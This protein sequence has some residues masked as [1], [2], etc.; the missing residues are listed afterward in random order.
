MHIWKILR[1]F[2]IDKDNPL[3]LTI[4]NIN[5]VIWKVEYVLSTV[6]GLHD[7]PQNVGP[8][9]LLETLKDLDEVR[10]YLKDYSEQYLLREYL[11]ED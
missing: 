9:D 4:M 5:D 6:R 11:D 10:R 2:V 7:E 3:I 8:E 1:T